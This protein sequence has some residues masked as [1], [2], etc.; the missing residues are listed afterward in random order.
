MKDTK[1]PRVVHV[2]SSLRR[3]GRERQLSLL[4]AN[5]N[6]ANSYTTILSFNQEKDGHDYIGEYNLTDKV[7]FL[8]SK[9]PLMR[10]MEMIVYFWRV[11][12]NVVWTWGSR[13]SLYA[14]IARL[15][16][17]FA[18]VNG[19]VRGCRT[20]NSLSSRLD[21][22]LLKLAPWAAGNSCAAMSTYRLNE[23]FVLYN[24]I[25]DKFRTLITPE[26]REEQ[27]RK[28]LGANPEDVVI[29]TCANLLPV[30]DYPTA[31]K[32]VKILLDKGLPVRYLVL[33]GGFLQ[34]RLQDFID[35]SGMGERVF[36]A[37]PQK[38]TEQLYPLA[39][40]YLQTS[41]YESCSNSILEASVTGLPIVASATGGTPEVVDE[42]NGFLFARGDVAALAKHLEALVTQP[43]L[44]ARL[45]EASARRG[46][47]YSIQAMLHNYDSILEVVTG[48]RSKPADCPLLRQF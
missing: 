41:L 32:A 20:D 38:H 34:S 1:P 7:H 26:K 44:R 29:I 36:L 27:R 18:F 16:T 10:L 45:A 23:G 28:L 24:G 33:G 39:D 31:F 47:E 2:I 19:M 37:G 13:E 9:N 22:L 30:K 43:E 40:I 46:A 11:K 6:H 5:Y 12:P 21:S 3:G 35:Q 25:E 14:F 4:A 15:F 48:N 42:R 8:H 17:R